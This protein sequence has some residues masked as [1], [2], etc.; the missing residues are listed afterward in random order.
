MSSAFQVRIFIYHKNC[1][2]SV[3]PLTIDEHAKFHGPTLYNAFLAPQKFEH[4]PFENDGSCWNKTTGVEVFFI[5]MTSF[6]NF[7]K[8]Y[9]LVQK[10]LGGSD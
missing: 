3:R 9:E 7:I 6:L 10:L 2:V 4:P 5:G 1:F 8:I